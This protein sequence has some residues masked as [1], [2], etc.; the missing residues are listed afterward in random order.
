MS[1]DAA[2]NE[3]HPTQLE[4]PASAGSSLPLSELGLFPTAELR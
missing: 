3:M 1:L 4:P 2:A